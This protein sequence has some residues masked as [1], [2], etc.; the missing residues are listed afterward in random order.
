MHKAI[1]V[2]SD[3]HSNTLALEA[4]LQDISRRGI[5]LIVNLG[6]SLY[7][8]VDPIGT[9]GLLMEHANIVHIMGNCDQILLEESSD[10]ETYRFVKP[11]ITSEIEQWIRSF[12]DTWVFEDLLFC[13]GTPFSN[14]EYLV[15]EVNEQGVRYKSPDRLALGLKEISQ[16]Y[17]FCGHSH[18]PKTIFLPDGKLVVNP[19]SVGLPAY[20]EEAPFAHA[21]ESG[22]P[23]ADYAIAYKT[24]AEGW[25]IEHVMVRYDWEQAGSIAEQNGRN[26]YA[27]AIKTGRATQ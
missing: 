3:I 5:N 13:H 11:R 4:V 27:V 17:I 1:A 15:E 2:I 20:E 25:N 26:D 10:S 19:G 21:M 14:S 6:D 16:K 22:S 9:A 18:V 8:P 24:E 7:G 23:Y 12:Q